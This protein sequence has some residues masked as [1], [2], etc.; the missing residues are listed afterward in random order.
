MPEKLPRRIALEVSSA[1][2]LKCPS[3][4]NPANEAFQSVVGKGF[5]KLKDFRDL[6]DANPWVEEIEL[7]NYGEILL[8]PELP[9][10]LQYAHE[11]K[12]ILTADNGVN[13]NHATEAV[14]EA[15]VK[16]G[17]RSML[18]SMDGAS[19][20]TYAVYRVK[21][22]FD[23]VIG[24]IRKLNRFKAQ[25]RSESPRLTWQFVIF[26]HNE[27]EIERA[28]ALA[29][30]LGMAFQ[31]KLNWDAKFSPVRDKELARK[32]VGYSS[33][34]EYRQKMGT[35]YMEGGCQSLWD[36]PQINWDGKML[37]CCRNFW[38]D[39]GGNAFRDGLKES[40]NHEKMAYARGMLLG[41]NAPREDIPCTTCSI[42][43]DMK[44]GGRRIRRP[45]GF[46][47]SAIKAVYHAMGLHHVR[48]RLG[49]S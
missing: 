7:S 10:I 42:Y 17:L 6:L 21:G 36:K 28:R 25:Y 45:P 46:P 2:Q 31:M 43:L 19:P 47:L 24:N 32:A 5:L 27:H 26:G 29:T 9:G 41:R 49:L 12:V 39:F 4:P 44:A 15:M 48:R 20:E 16:Y 37:G 35:D 11:R 3:C 23:T 1:C 18:C 34:E 14:L 33:R 8:N 13:L 30:E 22:D 40:L 38:G